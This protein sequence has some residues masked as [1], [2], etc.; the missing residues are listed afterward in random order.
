LSAAPID[1]DERTNAIGLFNTA[2]SYW[3]SAAY[4]SAANLE[5]SHPA[6]PVTFLLC[7]AIELYLKAYLRA[8]KCTLAQLKQ[9]GHRVAKLAKAASD[10]G[11]QLE[12]EQAEILSHIDEADVAIEARYI[13]TGF[14]D[15]PT[16]EALSSVAEQL[17]KDIAAALTGR[18]LAVREEKFRSVRQAPS[19][20]AEDT[21]RV[22]VRLFE[23][24]DIDDRSEIAIADAL[25]IDPPMLRYHLDRLRDANFA[26]L[27]S[28]DSEHIYWAIKSEGRRHVVESGLLSP[29]NRDATHDE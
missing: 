29:R 9:L 15:R 7:H 4:L 21:E 23:V 13:V 5:V 17:D 3:R 22:L 28:A 12:A 2:R 8:T 20:M 24:K 18:G 10:S 27:T 14:K 25:D 11:L 1:D 26:D 19:N 16:N 6:A